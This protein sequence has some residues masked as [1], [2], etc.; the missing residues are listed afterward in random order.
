MNTIRTLCICILA[1]IS[2]NANAL[3]STIYYKSTPIAVNFTLQGADKWSGATAISRPQ[4]LTNSYTS[5]IFKWEASIVVNENVKQIIAIAPALSVKKALTPVAEIDGYYV[6]HPYDEA[7]LW[8]HRNTPIAKVSNKKLWVALF[9]P[10][11]E[12]FPELYSNDGS[13]KITYRM[14]QNDISAV[15]ASET[16]R[17]V[18]DTLDDIVARNV[19]IMIP[20]CPTKGKVF[21]Y[22]SYILVA[23]SKAEML[24]LIRKMRKSF[25]HYP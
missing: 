12:G 7:S 2:V 4:N 23:E 14:G 11:I 16:N 8:A 13:P 18:G 21:V 25:H 15:L 20:T 5:A 24:E 9:T 17:V 10:V 6:E 3:V 1:I 19:C 22:S